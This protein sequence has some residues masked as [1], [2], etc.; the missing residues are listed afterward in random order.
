MQPLVYIPFPQGPFMLAALL[1]YPVYLLFGLRNET[2]R[3]QPHFDV[4]FEPFSQ[5]IQLPRGQREQALQQVVQQYA[6][7]LQDFTLQ[8]PLQ[9]YNFFNFWKLS[10][11]HDDN[12]QG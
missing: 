4:Y 5:Q 2:H 7:R 12:Q 11:Q 9:W 3:S 6:Q 10:E 1:K 8:A